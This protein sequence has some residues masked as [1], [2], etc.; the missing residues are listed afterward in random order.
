MHRNF[1]CSV[2]DTCNLLR[3]SVTFMVVFREVRVKNTITVTDDVRTNTL[4]E[5]GDQTLD[6]H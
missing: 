1:Y 2:M 4:L 6:R 3:V 5:T